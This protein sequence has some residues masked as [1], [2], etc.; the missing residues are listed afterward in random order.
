MAV[1][2]ME[3]HST[4]GC[5]LCAAL[6]ICWL[7]SAL[8]DKN[9]E[10][11]TNSASNSASSACP[12]MQRRVFADYAPD[13]GEDEEEDVDDADSV[14]HLQTR[15]NIDKPLD[16]EAKT[17][18]KATVGGAAAK[19]AESAA[20]HRQAATHPVVEESPPQQEAP[21]SPGTE[22]RLSSQI[23]GNVMPD[24]AGSST[25]G[26]Y[27]VDPAAFLTGYQILLGA[28]IGALLVILGAMLATALR[29]W[30]SGHKA[31]VS[32]DELKAAALG[33][34]SAKAWMLNWAL[35]YEPDSEEEESVKAE[36]LPEL[37]L[38]PKKM[39]PPIH[40]ASDS[41]DTDEEEPEAESDS[42]DLE[43]AV[44]VAQQ[45]EAAN[46]AMDQGYQYGL[47]RNARLADVIQCDLR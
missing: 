34:P 9:I 45:V 21:V 42:G 3:R 41:G 10:S 27:T 40:T 20:G 30:L 11:C 33:R 13:R 46:E 24:A 19:S 17:G 18:T 6:L 44:F 39:A 7:A 16:A 32:P 35:G 26:A 1:F 5:S 15:L 37:E 14:V 43:D 28:S 23:A 31:S 29:T 38:R 8:A 12:S 4:L 2:S 36:S 25:H 22:P 47:E